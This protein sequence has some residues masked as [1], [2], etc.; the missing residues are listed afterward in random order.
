MTER[1]TGES[2]T[3]LEDRPIFLPVFQPARIGTPDP[4]SIDGGN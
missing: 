2:D 1:K 3:D 4:S